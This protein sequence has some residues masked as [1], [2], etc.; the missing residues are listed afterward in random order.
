MSS[1]PAMSPAVSAASGAVT[2][3]VIIPIAI[4]LILLPPRRRNLR[5]IPGT[6][7]NDALLD[8]L[9]EFTAIQPHASAL[10]AIVNLDALPFAH[11]QIDLAS[12]AEKAVPST[13]YG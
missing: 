7:R 10:G 6:F 9:V 4:G 11:H 13:V 5:L 12:G 1:A 3:I 2:V 8:D